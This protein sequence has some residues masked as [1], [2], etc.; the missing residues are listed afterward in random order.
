MEKSFII[1][2][3]NCGFC[4]KAIMFI[5]TNDKNNNFK[6]VSSLSNFGT[7]LL[8]KHKIK[9]LEK[10]TIILVENENEIYTKS[11]SIRKIMLKLPYYKLIG[12]LMFVLPRILSDYVYD[13]ISK[14]RK[15]IV[16]N[17]VCEIPNSEIRKKFI[18]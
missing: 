6:F 8:S 2:D 5:A 15:R 4:N 12:N 10:S 3:G 16:K 7:T 17:S 14:N 1:F 9:G 11:I 13:F 18:M